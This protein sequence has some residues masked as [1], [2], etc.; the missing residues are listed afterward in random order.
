M[1]RQSISHERL[2]GLAAYVLAPLVFYSRVGS[3][4]LYLGL[5]GLVPPF[6]LLY[7]EK[8]NAFVRFHAMQSLVFFGAVYLLILVLDFIPILGWIIGLLLSPVITLVSFIVWLLLL[9]RTYLGEKYYLPYFGELAQR[10]V[11]KLK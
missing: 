9:W 11:E 10:Q 3:Y 1:A 4:G 2:L 5:L 7:K 8:K 6:F